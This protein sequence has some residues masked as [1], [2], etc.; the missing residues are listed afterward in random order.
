MDRA[1][2]RDVELAQS[3]GYGI[4]KGYVAFWNGV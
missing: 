1:I 4:V 2:W 3:D